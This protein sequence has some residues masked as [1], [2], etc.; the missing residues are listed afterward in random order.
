M[1]GALNILIKNEFFYKFQGHIFITQK[2]DAKTQ[3]IA[4]INKSELFKSGI[5][6]I[7]YMYYVY[8]D[9]VIYIQTF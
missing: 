6:N 2:R 8:R 7:D 1:I 5:R 3:T 4:R 9:D